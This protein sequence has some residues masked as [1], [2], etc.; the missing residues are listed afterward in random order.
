M[1]GTSLH[2]T[3]PRK[4]WK[5]LCGHPIS[6]GGPLLMLIDSR[7]FPRKTLIPSRRAGF[8]GLDQ[9]IIVSL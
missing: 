7:Y 2:K 8:L 3:Q 5:V 4:H 6:T 9:L 1:N